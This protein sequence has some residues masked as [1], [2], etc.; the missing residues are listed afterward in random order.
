[1]ERERDHTWDRGTKVEKDCLNYFSIAV[2]KHH[3]DPDNL[4]KLFGSR[5][6]KFMTIMAGGMA[7]GRR[8]GT[9][10]VAGSLH[11]LIYKGLKAL[12]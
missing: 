7:A 8:H 6:L 2:Q 9:G 1:R 3:H 10:A 12:I 5:E 4:K 11:H